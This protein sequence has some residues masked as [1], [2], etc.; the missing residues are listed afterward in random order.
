MAT[1]PGDATAV[2]VRSPQGG[3]PL[4]A[5]SDGA[6]RGVPAQDGHLM[7]QCDEFEF[8]G[9]VMTNPERE[10]GTEGGQKREHADD[11]TALR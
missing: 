4:D 9:A 7:S 8:Q 3:K 5:R 2:Q 1:T 11:G 10:Q 6:G